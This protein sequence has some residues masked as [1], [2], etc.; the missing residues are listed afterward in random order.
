[1]SRKQYAIATFLVIFICSSERAGCE[2]HLEMLNQEFGQYLL[3]SPMTTC[4]YNI[5]RSEN[6]KKNGA[7]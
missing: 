1:M 3:P 5:S 4:N 2:D 6:R 7:F